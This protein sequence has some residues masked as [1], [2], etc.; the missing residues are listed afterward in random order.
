[1]PRKSDKSKNLK[2][3]S[4]APQFWLDI[5]IEEISSRHFISAPHLASGE[6]SGQTT[7]VEIMY[8]LLHIEYY[9]TRNEI[10]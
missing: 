7:I 5:D 4:I 6:K 1:M 2:K 3:K 9:T 10:L 8:V